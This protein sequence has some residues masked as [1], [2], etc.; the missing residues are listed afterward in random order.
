MPPL[1]TVRGLQK[2]FGSQTLFSELGFSVQDG[3]RLGILGANGSGKSTLLKILAGQETANAGEIQRMKGLRTGW[4]PQEEELPAEPSVSAWLLQ[5]LA[6]E[7]LDP[8]EAQVRV[9]IMLGRAGFSDPEQPV[10][11]LSGGWRKRL[12]IARALLGEPRLLLL[13]EPTNHLDLGGIQWLEELLPTLGITLVLVCHDRWFMERVCT[14]VG[15]LSVRY[16]DGFFSCAGGWAAFQQQKARFLEAQ[17]SRQAGMETRLRRELDWLARGPKA[18]ATKA[19]YRIDAANK[20][21]EDVRS[22]RQRTAD[23]SAAGLAFTASGRQSR[24]LLVLEG[25][26]KSLGGRLLFQDLSLRLGPGDRLGLLGD[27]GSGKTTLL[28][29]ICD[30]ETPDT[31]TLRRADKLRI[32]LFEQD[33]SRLDKTATLKEALCP[34]GDQVTFRGVPVHVNAWAERF[35]FRKEQLAMP[36]SQLSGGEQARVLLTRLMLEE[37][38]LLILDEPTNDLDLDTRNLLEDSL[39]E[40]PGAVIL[41]SHD[42]ALLDSVCTSLLVLDGRGAAHQLADLAQWQRT[43][44]RLLAEEEAA[45]TVRQPRKPAPANPVPAAPRLSWKQEQELKALEEKLEELEHSLECLTQ[46]LDLPE[47]QQDPE[48][49]RAHCQTLQDEQDRYD[50]TFLR[51]GELEELRLAAQAARQSGSRGSSS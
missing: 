50:E 26:G 37:A 3:E 1:I 27:N 45:R 29:I 44:R 38:D 48:R 32:V 43:Q 8:H 39:A 21:E 11:Q 16:P 41:V 36:V 49:L 17:L 46:E 20:L 31:G 23:N 42:R 51:W 30:T 10:G 6:G 33:R 18:R 22:G 12:A 2:S 35:L 7:A 25:L 9:E 13:D 14:R 28:R 15:E 34:T 40:F 5:A 4:L 24:Q 19:Q 47:L